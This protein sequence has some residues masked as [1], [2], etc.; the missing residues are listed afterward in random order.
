MTTHKTI[1]DARAA[2]KANPAVLRIIEINHA[3][4]GRCFIGCKAPLKSLEIALRNKPMPEITGLIAEYPVRTESEIASEREQYL[5]DN[6]KCERCG[7][8]ID[9]N[10]AYSQQEWFG[11][12]RVVAHYC[13]SCRALLSAFG[14][15]EYTELQERAN[16]RHGH[17]P[18]TKD[19]F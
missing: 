11:Q 3:S 5:R 4:E 18:Y 12:A 6:T 8:K 7:K 10:A 1:E 15:G 16:A 14:A 17:E 19:D 13:D 2:A 9:G